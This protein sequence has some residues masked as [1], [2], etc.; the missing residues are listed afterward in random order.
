MHNELLGQLAYRNE[1]FAEN[2]LSVVQCGDIIDAVHAAVITGGW[3]FSWDGSGPR[4]IR[5]HRQ[6]PPPDIS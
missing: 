6:A 4:V 5:P 2:A 1:S 3:C